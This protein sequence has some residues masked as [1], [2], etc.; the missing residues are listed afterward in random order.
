MDVIFTIF[1][2]I[3][4]V[5]MLVMASLAIGAGIP[6]RKMLETAE[7]VLVGRKGYAAR[8]R[9]LQWMSKGCLVAFVLLTVSAVPAVASLVYEMR[10]APYNFS[11]GGTDLPGLPLAEAILTVVGAVVTFVFWVRASRRLRVVKAMP[12]HMK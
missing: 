3:A 6:S 9:K 5:V 2:G 7:Y 1:I 8:R 11:T 4:V 10:V 12:E